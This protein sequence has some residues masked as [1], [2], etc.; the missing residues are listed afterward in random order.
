[1]DGDIVS[2][3]QTV[4][5]ACGDFADA[6]AVAEQ[7]CAV[8]RDSEAVDPVMLPADTSAAG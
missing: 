4:E 2:T 5:N 8:E 6:S 1:M 7:R 3:V